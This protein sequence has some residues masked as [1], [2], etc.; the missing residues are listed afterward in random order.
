MHMQSSSIH[1]QEKTYILL[2]FIQL[3]SNHLSIQQV[4]YKYFL[5]L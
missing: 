4:F 1:L 5:N 3:F 2:E